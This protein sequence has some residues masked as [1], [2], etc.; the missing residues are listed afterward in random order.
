MKL[1]HYYEQLKH[2]AAYEEAIVRKAMEL[3][4]EMM[5]HD[6]ITFRGTPEQQ[7]AKATELL[8]FAKAITFGPRFAGP[9]KFPL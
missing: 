3:G 1:A 4:A 8:R 6:E 2:A 7:A 5:V 9:L